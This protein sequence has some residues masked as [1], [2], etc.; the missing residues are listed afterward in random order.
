LTLSSITD[1]E[2]WILLTGYGLDDALLAIDSPSD[3]HAA[4]NVSN[5]HLKVINI[6]H[7]GCVLDDKQG[8]T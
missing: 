7:P 5:E 1:I 6:Q 2:L 4:S 8:V 3:E